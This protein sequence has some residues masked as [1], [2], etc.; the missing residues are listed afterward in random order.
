M[1]TVTRAPFMDA[2]QVAAATQGVTA[3]PDQGRVTFSIKSESS[4]GVAADSV[5]GPLRIGDTLDESREGV[6]HF[7]SDEPQPL[8]GENS[9]VSPAEYV[10]KGL[11]GCYVATLALLAAKRG[12]KLDAVELTINFDMDLQ[13]FLGISDE[14]RKGAE[15]ILVQIHIEAAD[16]SS[17]QIKELVNQLEET[18][19]IRDTLANPVDVRT[20]II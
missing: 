19:P 4:G 7:R 6:F 15:R 20:V 17:E 14:V 3:S 12:Y 8:L 9:A 5:T 11:A 10:M 2:D 18:S 16:L 13:G 1:T